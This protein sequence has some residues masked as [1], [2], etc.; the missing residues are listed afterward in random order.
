M[1]GYQ[2]ARYDKNNCDYDK[3]LRMIRNPNRFECKNEERISKIPWTVACVKGHIDEAYLKVYINFAAIIK[4]LT[5]TTD[6]KTLGENMYNHMKN[7]GLTRDKEETKLTQLLS[8]HDQYM[9]F[10]MYEL[11]FLI[12]ECHFIIDDIETVILFTKHDKFKGFVNH[13]FKE[14]AVAKKAKKEGLSTLCKLIMN[15]SYGSDGQNNEKFSKLGFFDRAK[16]RIKQNSSNFQHTTK[17]TDDL[18]ILESES[19]SAS[20]N[21]PLQSAFATLSNAKFWYLTFVYKFLYKCVDL[22]KF[23]FVYTDTD[24]FM[25][26]VAGTG[27]RQK[28]LKSL[29][30]EHTY[31]RLKCLGKKMTNLLMD[32]LED[33]V[34][35]HNSYDT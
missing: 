18:F 4:K 15:G 9:S 5:F 13:F 23:H 30:G 11:W 19:K 24:S 3:M 27:K 7:N 21:K 12:D 26:A 14:R 22:S 2:I 20:C 25:F 31:A 28:T 35:D 1:P 6:E 17:V 32:H 33:I 8:T 34:V 29:L 16:T 10:G